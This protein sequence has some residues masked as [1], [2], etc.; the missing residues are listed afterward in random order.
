MTNNADRVIGHLF[1]GDTAQNANWTLTGG[2]N[3]LSVS[4]GLPGILVNEGQNAT[5]NSVLAG[6]QGFAKLGLGALT[7]GGANRVTNGVR[8]AGGTLNVTSPGA[9]SGT[10]VASQNPV[11]VDDVSMIAT[12]FPEYEGLMRGLGASLT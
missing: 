9:L 3:T 6:S 5:V 10:L 4:G 12:S 2:T 7:L 8:V 11:T 1:F